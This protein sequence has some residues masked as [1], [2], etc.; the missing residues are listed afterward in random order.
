MLYRFRQF[1][2][3]AQIEQYLFSVPM[4]LKTPRAAVSRCSSGITL[5]SYGFEVKKIDGYL[6]S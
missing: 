1:S 2:R 5:S 3:H 4:I 6:C